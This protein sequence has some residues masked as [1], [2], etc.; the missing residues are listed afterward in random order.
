MAECPASWNRATRVIADALAEAEKHRGDYGYS[1]ARQVHD[2]LEKEGLLVH[3][4]SG[5]SKTELRDA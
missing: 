1:I 3:E 2:A 5:E 4:P